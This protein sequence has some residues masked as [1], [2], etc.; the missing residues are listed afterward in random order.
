MSRPLKSRAMPPPRRPA[1]SMRTARSETPISQ[2]GRRS[3]STS[4]VGGEPTN[5]SVFVRCRGRNEREKREN[6]GV[7][8]TT[9][10]AKGKSVELSMGPNALSNKTYYFDRV[11]SP[12]A[13][14]IMIYDEVVAPILDEVLAGF[15]CTIFAYG[16]TGTGK[17]YTMTGDISERSPL[18][19]NAG[20]IPRVLDSLF[21]KL[22][23][24]TNSPNGSHG[25]EHT[26]R[27]S[28]IE[29]YNEELRDLVS[30]D[31]R[32]KLKIY[33]GD[34]KKSSA[35]VVQG[36]EEKY[37]TS[38]A[39]GI[40]IL[41][42]GSHKRQVAAT[43]CNDLSSRSHTVF[44]ITVMTKRTNEAGEEYMTPG[45]LNLVDLAGSENI[46]HSGA[47]N[48]RAVEA[49]LI[50]K[51]LLTLGRV[52]NALVDRQQHIPYRESKLTRLLQDSLGGRTKTCII[53]TLSPAR[54]NLEET[55]STLD[56]AFR[57]KNIRNKP[58]INSL[59]SK[60]TLLK[61]YTWEIER[62]RSDLNATRQKNGIYL[63]QEVYDEITNESESR[64][65]QIKEHRETI[66][67]IEYNLNR[68][69]QE[70]FTLTTSFNS[71]KKD[72]EATKLALDS[73]QSV[74]EKTELVLAHTK[75][76]LDE[77]SFILQSHAR[78]E[79]N[80]AHL[81]TELVSVIG[82]AQN[83]N[84]ALHAK[85]R[86]RSE[87]QF[88]HRQQWSDTQKDV[89]EVTLMVEDRIQEFQEEQKLLME[90]LGSR[91]QR[92]VEAELEQ[93]KEAKADLQEK[94][95]AFDSSHRDVLDKTAKS[96]DEL[97]AVLEELKTLRDEVKD[98]VGAGLNDL[99]AA[100]Q[101]IS[102]GI[103]SEIDD[104]HSQLHG[105]Y[106]SLGRDFRSAFD[107]ML[108]EICEQRE[109]LDALRTQMQIAN[110]HV[111]QDQ[112]KNADLLSDLVAKE[113]ALRDEENQDLARKIQQMVE[114][115][116]KQQELRLLE[117]GNLP[118]QF[119]L[120]A[121][122]HTK[123]S[124]S[125]SEES[126][127]LLQ[128][129]AALSDQMATC[130]DSMKTRIQGDYAVSLPIS[131]LHKANKPQ[132]ANSRTEK[133]RTVTSS[134]H[135][136]TTRIVAEQVQHLDTE[137]R[138]FDD[139]ISRI[140]QQ[141][142]TAHLD[143]EKSFRE[144]ATTVTT[145]YDTISTTFS[146]SFNRIDGLK[147]DVLDHSAALQETLPTLDNQGAIR[148]PLS[149][150]REKLEEERLEEYIPT[151]LT[152][153]KKEYDYPRVI[154]RTESRDALL[155]RMRNPDPITRPKSPTKPVVFSDGSSGDT[156]P[157][158]DTASST[159]SSL[160]ELDANTLHAAPA[161]GPRENT[162]QL[163]PSL[164]RVAPADVQE[165][166]KGPVKKRALRSTV[167]AGREAFER[168]NLTMPDLSASVG[169]GQGF[170][171]RRLRRREGAL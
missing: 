153:N 125:F 110:D 132:T 124:S 159:T 105:S 77:E 61:E 86:R 156:A 119:K 82:H 89:S 87:L 27:T 73:A 116:A 137:M 160:R 70:L 30:S 69:I 15:N 170:P 7:V 76:S 71:L 85:L 8:V 55:I 126:E 47:E 106:L 63:T 108:R 131:A 100:A 34:G 80:L 49:G 139:V 83:D 78:T 150:L 62:L 23:A 146:N 97:T 148:Q 120:A 84:K 39:E 109:E 67:T 142:H 20:I 161:L 35:T 154:P 52:I 111:Q 44:T 96:K 99:G 36:M 169:A 59:L 6:S 152:P 51:S 40:Q 127:K 117:I 64:R 2:N 19:D 140:H 21:S 129:S 147:T 112:A 32:N 33:D 113:K 167:A 123:A 9:D 107:D 42:A 118:A 121:Q 3:P 16:Q 104:F 14:Q 91:M 45:K 145:S 144:L 5:I 56:Y 58:Q 18:P 4:S 141:N 130:R 79:E 164:K 68:K 101:R 50:N 171:G 149:D 95:S 155:A 26:V 28:F 17:T 54:S 57:A 136:E 115:N 93:L 135:D 103:L 1:S 60:K 134:V 48:K 90:R 24:L 25:P 65:V 53:A 66:E 41:A 38:A 165:P 29:L 133:L 157:R 13:D 92:F 94:S 11:F 163:S 151:G 166:T 72:N 138:S 31:D 168:E 102:V 122:T 74:L 88:N 158:P 128:R 98:K 10:G 43:K 75:K 37:I 12:A 143:R 162:Q 22:E 46:K 114:A 81:S